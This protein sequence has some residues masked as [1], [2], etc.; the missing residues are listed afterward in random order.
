MPRIHLPFPR[1]GLS[2]NFA[3]DEQPPATSRDLRNTRGLDP[4]TN[5]LRGASRAGFRK[6]CPVQVANAPIKR[7]QD[8]VYEAANLT[9]TEQGSTANVDWKTANPTKGSTKG[10]VLD[11]QNNVYVIDGLAGLAKFNS[12]GVQVWK[13]AAPSKDHSHEIQALVVQKSTGLVFAGVSAGGK[14]DTASLFCYQQKDDGLTELLWQIDPGGYVGQLRIYNEELYCLL[15]FPDRNRSYIRVYGNLLTSGV[16]ASPV[17]LKEWQVG[18]QGNDFDVS[19][20]DGA[21]FAACG[22]DAQRGLDPRSPF[23]TQQSIDWTPEGNLPNYKTRKWARHDASKLDSLAIQRQPN[24][25]TDEGGEVVVM[26]DVDGNGRNWIANHGISAFPAVPSTEAGPTYRSQGVG[27]LPGLSFDGSIYNGSLPTSKSGR[28]MVG[29]SASSTD[30][31]YRNEQLSPLPTYKGAQFAYFL[32]VKVAIDDKNVRGLVSIPIANSVVASKVLTVNRRDDNNFPGTIPMAGSIGLRDPGARASDIGASTP[33]A[34][35]PSGPNNITPGSLSGTGLAIITWIC[36][37]GVHDGNSVNGLTGQ[38]SRSLLRINGHP[39]DRWQSAP[40]NTQEAIALG[41][42]YLGSSGHSR[43]AGLFCEDLCLSDWYDQNGNQN[44]LIT[45]PAYPDIGW[46]PQSDTEVERIEGYLAHKWGMAHELETGQAAW[47]AITQPSDPENLTIDGITYRFTASLAQPN[48]VKIGADARTTAGN[49]YQAINRIGNPGVDYDQRTEKHPTY[50]ALGAIEDGPHSGPIVRMAIRS[51]SPYAPSIGLVNSAHVIW[52]AGNTRLHFGALGTTN[53][54]WPH[55]FTLKKTTNSRGGPPGT[56]VNLQADI[57]PNYLLQSPYPQLSKWAANTGKLVW[58]ATSGYDAQ[59]SGDGTVGQTTGSISTTGSGLGGVGFAVRSGSVTPT[60][61]ATTLEA[62]PFSVGPQQ[63]RVT[64]SEAITA[65]NFDVRKIGDLGDRFSVTG[66]RGDPWS[67]AVTPVGGALESSPIRC[68]TD[69][70]GNFYVPIF[71]TVAG[72]L[73]SISLTAYRYASN[74]SNAGVEFMR[75][76]G[77]PTHQEAY[78]VAVDQTKLDFPPSDAIQYS[79]R[80][81]LGV[82]KDPADAANYSVFA[83][84]LIASASVAGSVRASKTYA[85]AAGSVYRV[86]STSASSLGSGLD[87]AAQYIDCAVVLGKLFITDGKSMFVVDP[88]LDTVVPYKPKS[89][90]EFL[91]TCKILMAWSDRLV[92]ARPA[93]NGHNWFMAKKGDPFNCDIFPFTVTEAQAVEGS[94]SRTSTNSDTINGIF[95][96]RDDLAVF[97]C[98]H[99]IQRMTGDPMAGGTFHPISSAVGGSFGK[100]GCLDPFGTFYCFSSRGGVYRLG[101]DATTLDSLTIDKI[102]RRLEALDLT[103][104]RVELVWSTE[105]DG[106][107]VYV[108]PFGR[109]NVHVEHY[110]WERQTNAWHVDEF[111]T[112]AVTN[113][114]PTCAFVVDGDL[115]NDRRLVMGCEDGYIRFLDKTATNDDGFPIESFGLIGPITP[116]NDGMEFLFTDF[117]IVLAA[118]QYGARYYLYASDTA[119]DPGD[120]IFHGELRPGRNKILQRVRGASVWLGIGTADLNG[121]WAVES[122]AARAEQMGITR[123]L[124]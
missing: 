75:F 52:N 15:N 103:T 2:E 91:P 13:I 35:G 83:L 93:D 21:V 94:D 120:V 66:T 61:P 57:P 28:S 62:Q 46:S 70:F 58:V 14:Q 24:S 86:D 20:V 5:R 59:S 56:T 98:D 121:S 17:H 108:V 122:I 78:A 38:S 18:S 29:I 118:Q 100:S 69:P 45:C 10:V 77:L 116:A 124:A 34:Q 40:F 51:I 50:L 107:H 36:D 55:P 48:D 30:R 54:W 3:L 68:D 39:V 63:I 80:A 6:W 53:G 89:G 44:Q 119:N 74:G 112:D 8:V 117:E 90:G 71:S 95:A 65:D 115:P 105:E 73:Q 85:I 47:A 32:V 92:G 106:L 104:N 123:A 99:S 111:G 101:S 41:L 9:Y 27:G 81:W 97:L 49:L 33:P 113:M 72:S 43:F 67:I 110:F 76:G 37:G 1:G 84:R 26:E 87:P 23:S 4:R 19:P 42:A 22:A 102:S 7:I 25:D 88:K 60:D 109:G 12:S 31:S 79:E 11:A 16:G 114:Q 82:Q 96:I 64:T